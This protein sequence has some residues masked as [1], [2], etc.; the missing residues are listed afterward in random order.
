MGIFKSEEQKV[1]ER[2]AAEER[3]R[4]ETNEREYAS[5]LS[6]VRFFPGSIAEY[7]RVHGYSVE[8]IPTGDADEGIFLLQSL[9]DTDEGN[10]EWSQWRLEDI[11][12]RNRLID[13]NLEAVVNASQMSEKAGYASRDPHMR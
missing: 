5:K 11:E 8:V 6:Q 9:D 4:A 12:L 1:R 7:E 10:Y 3:V 13:Q 2:L